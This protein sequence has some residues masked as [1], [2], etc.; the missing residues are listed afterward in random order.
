[1]QTLAEIVD[2]TPAQ[3]SHVVNMRR[4]IDWDKAAKIAAALG[5]PLFFLF[6]VPSGTKC[7][8]CGDTLGEVA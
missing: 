8:P 3:F 7:N 5:W 1:M 6:E 2:M 4:D